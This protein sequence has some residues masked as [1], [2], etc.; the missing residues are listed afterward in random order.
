MSATLTTDQVRKVAQ[1]ARLQLSEADVARFTQQLGQVLGYVE[2]LNELNTDG[3]EP[4]A[5]PLEIENVL[6]EDVPI[7]SLAREAALSN[8]PKSDGR[9][10]L[11]PQILDAG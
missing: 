5:H 2:M 10:F 6:R 4:L 8:A 3:V 9:C 7:P 11:V 1:L